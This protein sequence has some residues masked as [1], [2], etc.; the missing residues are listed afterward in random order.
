MAGHHR[1]GAAAQ[2]QDGLGPRQQVARPVADQAPAGADEEPAAVGR[3]PHG[4]AVGPARPAAERRQ[5]DLTFAG[6]GLQDLWIE[7]PHLALNLRGPGP[8]RQAA[9]SA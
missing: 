4:R 6:G 9:G 3:D 2:V 1:H 7:L 5:L 8:G